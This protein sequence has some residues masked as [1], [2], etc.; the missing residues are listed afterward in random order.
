MSEPVYASDGITYDRCNI[1]RYI[2]RELSVT[3]HAAR[4]P[5]TNTPLA[6]TELTPDRD[7]MAR[8][9]NAVQAH[10]QRGRT[11]QQR[12]RSIMLEKE[13]EREI[14]TEKTRLEELAK[15][16]AEL[17]DKVDRGFRV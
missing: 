11:R 15:A 5:V 6:T 7:M 2:E 9:H 10:G 17:R 8:I 16:R 4:S 13:R 1:E 3:A 14:E 12:M